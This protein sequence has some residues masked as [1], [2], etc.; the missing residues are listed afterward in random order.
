MVFKIHVFKN[1]PDVNR[2]SVLSSVGNALDS[3]EWIQNI[4]DSNPANDVLWP[5]AFCINRPV[6]FGSS[7]FKSVTDSLKN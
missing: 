5:R 6:W 2:V 1:L 7:K 3:D 4:L